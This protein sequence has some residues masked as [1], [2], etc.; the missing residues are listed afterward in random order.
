MGA[1]LPFRE[2]AQEVRETYQV[3]VSEA[4]TRQTTHENGRAAVELVQ[5]KVEQFKIEQPIPTAQPD[6]LQLSADGCFVCTTTDGWRE[7]KTLAI[8]EVEVNWNQKRAEMVTET[9]NWSYYSSIATIR[10]FEEAALV[11]LH[12][13][14]VENAQRLFSVN[15]G[16][17]WIQSF[18]DYHCPNAIRI[19]DF[20]HA[21]EHVAAA[22]K[23]ALGDNSDLFKSWYHDAKARLKHKPPAQSIA[24]LHLLARQSDDL[25]AK[26]AILDHIAYLEPR[27][28]Q[29]DYP[30]FQ[31]RHYPIGSGSVESSHKH[32]VQK[33]MK[34]AGMRWAADNIDPMLALRTLLAND[35]WAT[36]WAHISS[37]RLQQSLASSPLPLLTSTPAPL[38]PPSLP[39]VPPHFSTPDPSPQPLH[40]WRRGIWP[41]PR[42]S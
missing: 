16:A 12:E 21:A 20:S 1:K 11:E 38:P 37:S 39:P 5:E 40:P 26:E 19:L 18:T 29:I 7:V 32:V 28:D 13:R 41:D 30:F 33:R 10:E 3:T 35:R 42:F 24:R 17:K 14:G 15:D 9:T 8:G 2:A 27:I 22:G 36:G 31:D 4:T 34:Q 25:A 23:A 6:Q